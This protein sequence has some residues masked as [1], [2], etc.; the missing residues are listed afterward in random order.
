LERREIENS[1]E[2]QE[3]NQEILQVS[4]KIKIPDFKEV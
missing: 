2:N 1:Q 3:K 4:W